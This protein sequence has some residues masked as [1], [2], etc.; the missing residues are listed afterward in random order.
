MRSATPGSNDVPL[1]SWDLFITFYHQLMQQQDEVSEDLGTLRMLALKNQWAGDFS[2]EP[3]LRN[4]QGA[5]VITNTSQE[6]IWVSHHFT[7]MTGYSREEAIFQR[8][9]FLQ[10]A[11]TDRAVLEPVRSAIRNK[12]P[13]LQ[14][15]IV[16]YRKNGE[17]YLCRIDIHPV[18]NMSGELTHFIAFEVEVAA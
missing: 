4:Q 18:F 3:Y 7:Q 15:T 8:P 14:Q 1:L 2:F 16:N 11:D 10:G 5:I 9:S 17:R 6:I 12:V 13:V